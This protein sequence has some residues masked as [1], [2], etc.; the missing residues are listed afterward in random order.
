MLSLRPNCECCDR[1][2]GPDSERALI[3]SFE[4]TFCDDCAGGLLAGVCPNCGG[5]LVLPTAPAGERAGTPSGLHR[6]GAEGRRLRPDRLR[7]TGGR[8]A[9]WIGVTGWHGASALRR[10]KPGNCDPLRS[11]QAADVPTLWPRRT[12]GGPMVWWLLLL[13]ALLLAYGACLAYKRRP[14]GK[15]WPVCRK[16]PLSRPEQVLYWRLRDACP[17][18]VVLAQV[19]IAQLLEVENVPHRQAIFNRYRQLVADFVVCT[20][21]FNVVAVIELD[22]RSHTTPGRADADSRKSAALGAQEFHCFV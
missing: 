18:H 21:A 19:A 5:E 10:D 20:P 16:D 17:S 14:V 7:A 3:C 22:D 4:C 15:L 13:A 9:V 11:L 6:E 8:G 2:L 1:D 12:W